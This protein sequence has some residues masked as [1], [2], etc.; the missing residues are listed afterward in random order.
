MFNALH[1]EHQ[2]YMPLSK[3]DALV[4]TYFFLRKKSTIFNNKNTM[5]DKKKKIL[6]E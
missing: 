2:V 4:T 3:S 1:N 5:L 6:P